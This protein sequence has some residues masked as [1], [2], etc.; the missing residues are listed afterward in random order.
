MADVPILGTVYGPICCNARMKFTTNYLTKN[1]RQKQDDLSSVV[2]R[3]HFS[4]QPP[5]HSKKH[6]RYRWVHRSA[7]NPWQKPSLWV[8]SHV[9]NGGI[10]MMHIYE[11]LSKPLS[12]L[13]ATQH[14]KLSTALST[15]GV[16]RMWGVSFKCIGYMSTHI[17]FS[18]GFF[19]ILSAWGVAT[20]T[21]ASRTE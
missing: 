10:T 18:C 5:C 16:F 6:S 12:T 14:L 13:N 2:L 9:L 20:V 19:F 1:V 11:L 3:K 17:S 21:A 4:H 15:F 7:S 8:A